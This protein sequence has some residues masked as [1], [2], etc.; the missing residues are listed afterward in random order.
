[1]SL[2]ARSQKGET[3]LPS[4]LLQIGAHLR[5]R[6]QREGMRGDTAC[7]SHGIVAYRLLDEWDRSCAHAQLIQSHAKENRHCQ[8]ITCQ[9]AANA[10]LP[11]M[12]ASCFNDH[13]YQAQNGGM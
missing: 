10:Y 13:T 1:M 3:C 2:S 8:R 12:S 4:L 9:F 11:P 6:R 5:G 7:L